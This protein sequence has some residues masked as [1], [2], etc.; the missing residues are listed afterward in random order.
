[1]DALR[2]ASRQQLSMQA[3]LL[4]LVAVTALPLAALLAYQ[5]ARESRTVIET[6][7]HVVQDIASDAAMET[8]ASLKEVDR[9]LNLLAVRPQ[10]RALDA[11]RCDPLFKES[12][13]LAANT[14]VVA[15]FDAAGNLVCSSLPPRNGAPINV[16]GD[17]WFRGV[18]DSGTLVIGAPQRG[19]N[20]Q[21]WI[22]FMAVP[23]RSASGGIAGVLGIA[24]DLANFRPV[25]RVAGLPKAG[26]LAILDRGG[27][28]VSRYPDAEHWIGRNASASV[29]GRSATA[30]SRIPEVLLESDGTERL[31]AYE[32]VADSGWVVVAGVPTS[33]VFGPL[34]QSLWRNGLGLLLALLLMSALVFAVYRRIA[35]PLRSLGATAR[36]IGGGDLTVRAAIEGPRELSKVARAFNQMVERMLDVEGA[37]RE[38][39][40]HYHRL[41]LASPEAIC[42]VDGGCILLANPAAVNLFGGGIESATIGCE[43]LDFVHPGDRDRIRRRLRGVL[44]LAEGAVVTPGEIE[45]ADADVILLRANG[46][47][48]IAVLDMLP[49]HVGGVA[50]VMTLVTDVSRQRRLEDEVQARR[51]EAERLVNRQVAVHTALAIAHELNQPLGAVSAYCE[52]ALFMLRNGSPSP[53]RLSMALERGVQQAH[54]AGSSLHELVDF[55]QQED[56]PAEPFDL[57]TAIREALQLVRTERY[58]FDLMLELAPNLP[59]VMGRRAQVTKAIVNLLHNAVEATNSVGATGAR[60]GVTAA[61]AGDMAK[62]SVQD[63]GPGLTDD[64]AKRLFTPFFTTKA[65]GM[66]LGLV[67]TRA[68][69]EAQG[70]RLWHDAPAGNGGTVFTFTIPLAA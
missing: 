31:Y 36:A 56:A 50:A 11:G 17:P 24:I 9:T 48:A 65:G 41:F 16:A 34:R 59:P 28:V 27:F 70:G 7:E 53:E 55:L 2:P 64:A 69:V 32:P 42:V 47:V 8:E 39:E 25:A 43:F 66:G 10:V 5:V 38:R 62:V 54:R 29:V 58:D 63:S 67:I 18:M 37:L 22:C 26:V 14:T 51:D 68:L 46:D 21:R 20:T 44:A 1:M 13:I 6:A 45:S 30:R 33:Q 35:R 19:R 60:V 40:D 61:A 57:A 15:S 4:L 52:A 3:L 49:F 23:I 12:G